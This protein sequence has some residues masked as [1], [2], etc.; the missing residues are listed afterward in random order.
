MTATAQ[1]ADAAVLEISLPA[2]ACTSCIHTLTV[3]PDG[4]VL[5]ARNRVAA[6]PPPR[7]FP[8]LNR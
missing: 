3:L 4:V 1:T 8:A 2:D 5:D 7:P 6:R